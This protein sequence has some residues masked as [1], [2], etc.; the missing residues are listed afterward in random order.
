[1]VHIPG[2]RYRLR[3]LAAAYVVRPGHLSEPADV[4]VCAGA[5]RACHALELRHQQ[6][7]RGNGTDAVLRLCRPAWP[8][9]GIDLSGLYRSIDHAGLLHLGGDVWR[10]EPVWLHHAT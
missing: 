8:V 6:T 3:R 2:L 10:D 5:A 7:V 4:G 1:M 9:S